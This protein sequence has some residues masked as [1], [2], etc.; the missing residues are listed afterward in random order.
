MKDM[1]YNEKFTTD[2]VHE[3]SMVFKTCSNNRA[4][5]IGT[6][7]QTYLSNIDNFLINQNLSKL[8][9]LHKSYKFNDNQ[10][11]KIQIHCKQSNGYKILYSGNINEIPTMYESL[12]IL[13]WN[14]EIALHLRPMTLYIYVKYD[15]SKIDHA[16]DMLDKA[17]YEEQEED[18]LFRLFTRRKYK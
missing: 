3:V 16:K 2:K 1:N 11:T 18:S 8:I 15:Q 5:W 17:D 13:P 14:E 12:K 6:T 10:E 7:Q 4:I 9:S